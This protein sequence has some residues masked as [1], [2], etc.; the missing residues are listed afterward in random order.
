MDV[1]YILMLV[2]LDLMGLLAEIKPI[3]II[4]RGAI[5]LLAILKASP[6][7]RVTANT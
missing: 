1:R 5:Q 4:A 3:I 2:V 7:K 6:K